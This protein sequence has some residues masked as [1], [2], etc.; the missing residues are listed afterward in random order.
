MHCL[1]WQRVLLIACASATLAQALSAS[2]RPLEPREDRRSSS[3]ELDGVTTR[4]FG[5]L[6]H[7]EAQHRP[8]KILRHRWKMAHQSDVSTQH[9]LIFAVEQA[10]IDE[11]SRVT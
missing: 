7:H 1:K 10:S 4:K 6:R 2:A 9:K 5:K 3:F 8:E 11:L